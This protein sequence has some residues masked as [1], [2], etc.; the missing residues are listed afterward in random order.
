[1]TLLAVQLLNGLQLGLLLFLI[2][3]GLT[4]VFGIADLL[5]LAHGTLV[6]AGAFLTAALAVPFGVVPGLLL[7]TALTALVGLALERG[8]VKHLYA[9]SH[10][11]QV[12]ATFG[13]VLVGNDVAKA[14]W[15]PSPIFLSP[16]AWLQGQVDFG[17]FRYPSARLAITAAGLAVALGLWWLIARTRIGVWTRAAA[18]DGAM[19]AN[20]GVD[21]R[22]LAMG[23]FALGAALAGFAGG[24]T[25]FLVAV[26]IGMGEA[27]L[28]LAFVVV[29]V[30]GLGSVKGALVG[31]LI[32]GMADTLGRAFLPAL[33]ATVTDASTADGAGAALGSVMIY[34]V[35]A[36]VLTVRPQGLYG[37]RLG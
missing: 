35:M 34:V 13:L 32:V 28:I 14:I 22:M 5:N 25:G 7:A 10:L 1:M 2:A 26:Q 24:L 8:V 3:A 16:P 6:M 4:L 37:T 36:A 29:V 27:V 33:L 12:L 30:G 17:A 19:A 31:A 21:T 20:L 11:D 9:R 18:D 23:V 15:G